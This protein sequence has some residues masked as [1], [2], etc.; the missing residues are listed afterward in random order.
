MWPLLIVSFATVTVVLDRLW[1]I[2]RESQLRSPQDVQLFLENLEKN[3]IEDAK[4]I[5][6]RSTDYVVRVLNHALEH[7]QF[8]LANAYLQ[9]A[10]REL[11]RFSRGLSVLDT[12]I[13]LAPLLGLLGTVTGLIY[14]FGLLGDQ[15]LQAPTALTGGIAQA[16]IATAFGLMIAV[17]ALVPFNYLNA[18]L[19]QARRELE[20][21]GTQMELI[22]RADR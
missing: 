5:G 8:S 20:D 2:W 18:R 21:T 13:T 22:L 12:V 11:S 10:N 7:R 14:S 9:A 19:E 1:F 6:S 15:E 16:L 4:A 3:K 17:T